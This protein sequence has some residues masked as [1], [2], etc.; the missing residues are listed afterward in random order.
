MRPSTL[1][2][3]GAVLCALAVVAGAFGAHALKATLEADGQLENWRTAVRYQMWHGLAL[4][5]CA[6]LTSVAP[7][8]RGAAVCFGLGVLLFSGSIYGLAL[9]GPGAVLGPITPVG[10]LLLIVGWALVAA[11]ALRRRPAAQP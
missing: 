7:I 9:G 8:G 10:G 4:V 5:A 1:V 2:A 11:G 3:L 6:G